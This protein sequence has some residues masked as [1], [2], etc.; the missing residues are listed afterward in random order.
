MKSNILKTSVLCLV[1]ASLVSITSV[2]AAAPTAIG[3]GIAK[4]S[5]FMAN[6]SGIV[7]ILGKYGVKGQ[8]ADQL[9]TYTKRALSATNF[10]RNVP[11]SSKRIL[12]IAEDLNIRAIANAEDSKRAKAL[13]K[14]LNSKTADLD[15]YQVKEAF[16]NLYYLASRYGRRGSF[17][18]ACKACIGD[19]LYKKGFRYSLEVVKSIKIKSIMKNHIYGKNPKQLSQYMLKELD[20]YGVSY[21]K[22]ISDKA[23]S[24]EDERALA[25]FLA[26]NKELNTKVKKG[27]KL[28]KTEKKLDSFVKSVFAVSET[29]KGSFGDLFK[30]RFWANIVNNDDYKLIDGWSNL[31][32]DVKSKMVRENLDLETAWFKVLRE[33][34]GKDSDLEEQF[35]LLKR[36]RCFF[37]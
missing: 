21:T 18:L 3:K 11:K 14:T 20:K 37:R 4:L 19:S 26:L 5:E 29:E 2:F 33:R 28:T 36:M 13:L 31:L 12:E 8:E 24:L 17:V 6:D 1:L 9:K 35:N 16:N 23:F 25:I 32:R 10:S 7:E 30:H 34:A 27:A 15:E 22:A